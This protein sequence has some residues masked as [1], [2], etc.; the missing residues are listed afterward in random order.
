M[1][2]IFGED[3]ELCEGFNVVYKYCLSKLN[4][5]EQ[6]IIQL[7]YEEDYTLGDIAKM[8]NVSRERIRQVERNAIRKFQSTDLRN[9]FY[10]GIDYINNMEKMRNNILNQR[11][12]ELKKNFSNEGLSSI[13]I[14][15]L[16]L[17]VRAFNSLYRAGFR[18]VQDIADNASFEKLSKVRN[19]GK[20]SIEELSSR[21]ACYGIVIAK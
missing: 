9:A 20:K 10:Y 21:V 7:R 13:A 4:E 8:Q 16:G 12:S 15:D 6:T 2:D 14:R 11:K 5:R 19:L 3:I 1:F 18:T 17:S